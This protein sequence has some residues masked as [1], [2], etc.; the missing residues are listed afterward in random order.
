[1]SK[2]TKGMNLDDVFDRPA[3]VRP[4]SVMGDI[5][6]AN[7]SAV[8]DEFIGT[9]EEVPSTISKYAGQQRR[10]KELVYDIIEQYELTLSL[11][12]WQVVQ[13]MMEQAVMTGV[14]LEESYHAG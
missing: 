5:L 9:Q 7:L 4:G 10:A 1:M 13:N 8:L 2:K 14:N 12:Q 6:D 11:K 3:V